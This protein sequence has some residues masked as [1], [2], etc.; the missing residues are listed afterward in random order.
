[1]DV[2]WSSKIRTSNKTFEFGFIFRPFD[3]R[4]STVI[5]W[6]PLFV[7][8]HDCAERSVTVTNTYEVRAVLLWYPLP[9]LRRA[10]FA[11]HGR[12]PWVAR[13]R[14]GWPPLARCGWAHVESETVRSCHPLSASLWAYSGWWRERAAQAGMADGII[15]ASFHNHRYV[16]IV[17]FCS[18]PLIP[19]K[20]QYVG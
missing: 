7:F 5:Y 20:D 19:E 10:I 14:R 17:I 4:L 1:M 15:T 16:G 12:E 13:T 8:D 11:G 9:W 18:S 3:I 2:N 6:T